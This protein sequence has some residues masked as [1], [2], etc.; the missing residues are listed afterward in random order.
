[1]ALIET[2]W[3]TEQDGRDLIDRLRPDDL[4]ELQATLGEDADFHAAMR[5]IL[6]RSSHAWTILVDGRLG[7]IGGLVPTSTLLGGAEAQ[8]WMM[9]TTDMERRPGALTKVGI[10][11][12]AIMKGC[13]PRLANYVDA[14]NAKSIRWLKRL[15]FTVHART[16]PMGPYGLPF[17]PFDMDA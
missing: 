5:E 7:M 16:V 14:R 3:P 9:G 10:R 12:L 17:H 2:R 15:G 8:P 11:Y 4:A 13:Y 1:M 6:Q